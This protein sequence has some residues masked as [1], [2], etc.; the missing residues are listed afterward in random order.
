MDI[1]EDEICHALFQSIG[2][3]TKKWAKQCEMDELQFAKSNGTSTVSLS[4]ILA[5]ML[6]IDDIPCS[7]LRATLR[8]MERDGLVISSGN[9][10]N[11]LSWWLSGSLE[12]IRKGYCD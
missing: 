10:G 12:V 2:S 1:T 9:G 5:N 4:I 7:W 11:S 3:S 8:K 6:K